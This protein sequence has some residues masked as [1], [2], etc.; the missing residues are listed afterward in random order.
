MDYRSPYY[1]SVLRQ[2]LSS[3]IDYENNK[4][5]SEVIKLAEVFIIDCPTTTLLEAI[6]TT[7]PIFVLTQFL[8]L[9]EVAENLLKKRAICVSLVNN[10]I[11]E[12][13]YFQ[14]TGVYKADGFNNEYLK[15]FG[16]HLNDG[17]SAQRGVNEILS[18]I[19]SHQKINTN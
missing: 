2:Y 16:T 18:R 10:L 9:N 8:G 14:K 7:K 6:T 4:S 15:A 11:E 13:E 5:F 17:F 3:N 12:L 1:N 19:S